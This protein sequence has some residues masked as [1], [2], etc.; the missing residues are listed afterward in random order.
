MPGGKMFF[1]IPDN[2]EI[3]V[4]LVGAIP[5]SWSWVDGSLTAPETLI[6]DGKV[7]ERTG[8]AIQ[9]P[10]TI[11]PTIVGEYNPTIHGRELGDLFAII[12]EQKLPGFIRFDEAGYI[13]REISLA[14]AKRI[15]T[16]F[17]QKGYRGHLCFYSGHYGE[18]KFPNPCRCDMALGGWYGAPFLNEES[19][20][21][22]GRIKIEWDGNRWTE[23]Q[24]NVFVALCKELKLTQY[25]PQRARAIR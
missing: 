15:A 9:R 6:K 18:Y 3:M 19:G 1:E 20:E 17:I 14:L 16:S 12:V 21:Q 4:K 22:P 10:H 11:Y 2:Q 8:F 24:A 13:K 23:E 25:E 5:D 7:A